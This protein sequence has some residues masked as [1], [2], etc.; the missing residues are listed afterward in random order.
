[1]KVRRHMKEI[2]KWITKINHQFWDKISADIS[3]FL[4]QIVYF[5]NF[6]FLQLRLFCQGTAAAKQSQEV[7]WISA[8]NPKETTNRLNALYNPSRIQSYWP[9]I[10]V[11]SSVRCSH[12]F[13]R[14]QTTRW[15]Q[16][17]SE[18]DDRAGRRNR[19]KS[20][21]KIES[22]MQSI[23][24]LFD[25]LFSFFESFCPREWCRLTISDAVEGK[26]NSIQLFI[27]T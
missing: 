4:L 27:H 19:Q 13:N 15:W 12:K 22:T 2:F 8:N 6:F 18:K 5:L 26:W 17:R 7:S 3:T 21:K 16:V 9:F 10:V 11:Y 1:M 24:W 20:K 25:R 23:L 14:C